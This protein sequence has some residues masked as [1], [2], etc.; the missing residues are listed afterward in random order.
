[1]IKL[2]GILF[3][4]LHELQLQLNKKISFFLLLFFSL[5]LVRVQND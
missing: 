1:M 2:V 4:S 5:H 3:A